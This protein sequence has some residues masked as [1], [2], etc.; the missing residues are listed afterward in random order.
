MQRLCDAAPQE[1]EH[2]DHEDLCNHN[3]MIIL[4]LTTIIIITIPADRTPTRT[5]QVH[6]NYHNYHD[7]PSTHL[8]HDYHNYHSNG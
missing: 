1:A 2:G 8:K 4:L 5:L 7:N 6:Y 3:H